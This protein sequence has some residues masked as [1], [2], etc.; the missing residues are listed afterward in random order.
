MGYIGK[1]PAD[2]L[3][4]PHVDSAAITDGTII[5]AD[6]ANDAVT[7]AKLAANSVD[8]SEL[9]DGSVDNSHLAGSI[10]V[11]KTLLAGG[12]GLTLSTNTLNVDVSQTQI[13]SVGTLTTLQVGGQNSTPKL[14]WFYDHSNG[15][16]Y[17]AN[18]S[19]AGN[20][21]EI[22]SSS[23][24][25]EFFTGAVDGAS[26]TERMR[27][28][29]GGFVGIQTVDNSGDYTPQTISAPLHIL[30]KTASQGYGLVVQG[31]SN[32]NG[33]RIGIGEADSNFGTRANVIDIGFDSSTD[34]LYSRTGKDF[35][36]GVNSAERMRITSAGN[37]GIGCDNPANKL[38]IQVASNHRLG[39]WGDTDYSAIQSAN[40]ANSG[41]QKLRFDASE[42]HIMNGNVGINENSPDTRLH[43]KDAHT[44][45]P[46]VKLEFTGGGGKI[47]AFVTGGTENGD[48]TEAA[49]AIQ[50]NSNSDYRLK[51]N[52]VPLSDG[53]E[54]LNKLK[55]YI[56]NFKSDRDIKVDGFFAHE[57]QEVVPNAVSGEKD[58]MNDDGSI[59]AQKMDVAKIVPL[60][61]ASVQELSSK[62]TALENT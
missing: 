44:N 52:E 4:D 9:I 19:L 59:K 26:S 8:S 5:T 11:N 12:T 61:V 32:A 16:D 30:Q 56:F 21:L 18:I 1:V 51:E 50:Y 39:F 22:R 55:P 47:I 37:V 41:L 35:I 2:V 46:L 45:A 17:K 10:A 60:L 53:L 6:I 62:V 13:T 28:T 29:A 7:S 23:G 43:V 34:F 27:I 3:I 42:Y 48:I 38:N 31:N 14:E 36:F 15:D 20:D 49:G 54:K 25:M 24:T 40:D 33:G 58:A 57:V